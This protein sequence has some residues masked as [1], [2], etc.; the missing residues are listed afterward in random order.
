MLYVYEKREISDDDGTV[1]DIVCYLMKDNVKTL[2]L[3]NEV[4]F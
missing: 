3:I 2:I 1:I 4:L